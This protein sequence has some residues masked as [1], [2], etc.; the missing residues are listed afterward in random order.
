MSGQAT[1]WVLRHGPT[2]RAMRAVL[3]VI[4]DAA[5]RDGEHAHPGLAAI[6]EGSL[7]SRSTVLGTLRRLRE[8]GWVEVEQE[9]APGQATVFRIPGVAA[10]E[11]GPKSGPHKVQNPDPTGRLRGPE[12]VQKRSNPAPHKVQSGPDRALYLNGLTSNGSNA[13]ARARRSLHDDLE[14]ARG[15]PRLRRLAGEAKE[16]V[17]GRRQVPASE[18]PK[19]WGLAHELLE[20]GWPVGEVVESMVGA[21]CLSIRAVEVERERR[22]RDAAGDDPGRV[23]RIAARLRA[24]REAEDRR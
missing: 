4:A 1:G 19:V 22:R 5:N 21:S 17:L 8:E 20:A 15:R 7:Y 18:R 9:R 11:K 6:V 10:D 3:I 23:D 16:E 14:E 24:R 12:E 13:N 2:D